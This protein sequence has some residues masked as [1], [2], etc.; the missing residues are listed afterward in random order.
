MR[1]L[2]R[3]HRTIGIVSSLFLIL[4]AVS[5]FILHHSTDIGLDQRFV[6][7]ALL[8]S[9]YEIDEPE[10]SQ[11]FVQGEHTLSRIEDTLYFDSHPLYGSFGVLA[12]F[13]PAQS[14]YVAATTNGQVILLTTSGEIIE[15]LGSIHGVP[16]RISALGVDEKSDPGPII[17][18]EEGI[19]RLDLTT[20]GW[21]EIDSSAAGTIGWSTGGSLQPGSSDLIRADFASR[22]LTL[23]KVFLDIHNGNILGGFGKWLV[24]IMAGL[25]ILMAITGLWIWSRKR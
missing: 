9:W 19:H 21:E 5:G 17:R 3:V 4:L 24:D 16:Q 23:E 20:L 13:V 2:L 14:G 25:F 11:S 18:S 12:G 22:L 1:S 6:G 15:I 10:I 7:N 8:L